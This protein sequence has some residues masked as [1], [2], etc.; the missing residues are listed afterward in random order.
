MAPLLLRTGLGGLDEAATPG[1][2]VISLDAHRAGAERK[3]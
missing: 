1:S 3:H 2:N